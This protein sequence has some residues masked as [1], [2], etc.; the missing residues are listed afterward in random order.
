MGFGFSRPHARTVRPAASGA[1]RRLLRWTLWAV[2]TLLVI[3]VAGVA[4]LRVQLGRSLPQLDGERRLP[5]LTA[6]V[7]VARDELGVPAIT[8]ASRED[9]ARALGFVHA[10]D[11]F[12]QMD[13]ARRRAAGELSALIGAATVTLDTK[14]RALGLRHHA[15]RAVEQASPQERAVI[16]AYTSG[17]NAGLTALG[18]APPE[19]LAL[20]ASPEAWRPEDCALVVASMFLQLQDAFAV[21]ETRLGLVHEVL[22]PTLAEFLTSTA[23]SWETP[24]VGSAEAVPPIPGPEVLDLRGL[25]KAAMRPL[26][27]RPAGPETDATKVETAGG[28]LAAAFLG[29]RMEASGTW[30]SDERPGSNNWAVS[31][32]HTRDGAALLANDMHLGLSV[33]NTWYR[34]SLAWGTALEWRVAGVTLPGVPSL[35]VGSNG[36]VAWGFTNTT[37]DWSDI[38]LL[39]IDPRDPTRYR[40]PGG[41]TAFTTRDE[42][43]VV[44]G[45]SAQTVQVRETIWGP[46]IDPDARGRSR[47][48]A[49][50]P[51]RDGGLNYA[52]TGLETARTLEEALAVGTQAGVPAQNLVV[53]TR[54][55]RI[56][57]SIA[58]RI[59]RRVGFDGRTPVSWADGSRGWD[60]WLTPAEYPRVVDP[61]AGRLVTA[62]NRLVAG[63]DL[64]RLGD[65]GYDPGARARQIADGLARVERATPADMLAIQLDDRALFLDRWRTLLLEIL[66]EPAEPQA[67]N[68]GG[69]DE[70]RRVVEQ[71]WTGRASVDSAGYR[72]VREFRQHVAE[73]VLSPLFADV[74]KADPAYPVTGGR[75]G[76]G[77]LWALV[78]ARPAH[79]LATEFSTW[80]ELLLAA[81]DRAMA[82]ARQASGGLAAHTW[83]RFNASRIQHP[84]SR[85]VPQL[86][87][88]L[89]APRPELSGDSHMPRVQ[90]PDFGASERFAVSPGREGDG[91]FHMPGGQSGHPLSPHY[92][93]GH[94]AWI[95]G[96][97]TPFVPGT[98]LHTL[99]LREP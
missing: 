80:Q 29:P 73:L 53:A 86:A 57:W 91:Y 69:R 3:A 2:A 79:L 31:G 42:Q 81:A 71:T 87:R 96:R 60:G 11:R 84:L 50:V 40:T 51:L 92:L 49:W 59:P 39:E 68:A 65:G 17:V 14:T 18:A 83:G 99:T 10:Q 98:P 67:G 88:W 26:D 24:L 6:P 43:V 20:R 75:L 12:F 4:G 93:D 97:P 90:T 33:P 15:R 94:R 45:G 66:A 16:E 25:P 35:V 8:G 22:P 95:E 58:G 38:V 32:A 13:L 7:S 55:G 78:S 23:G 21:R 82:G 34:T 74:R 52:L 41:W 19:Y 76:E 9:V 54:D 85:A 61:P 1:G 89:D 46:V 36:H 72:L 28:R 64:A 62:N 30:D 37:A 47:A 63:A 27:P 5:G 77:P 44:A 48:V 56:A 70:L